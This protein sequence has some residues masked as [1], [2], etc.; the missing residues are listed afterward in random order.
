MNTFETIMSRK[1]VRKF[2]DEVISDSDLN[3]ILEAAMA[4]PSAANARPFEFL[5]IRDKKKLE[6][7]GEKA[8]KYSRPMKNATLGIVVCADKKRMFPDAPG[9]AAVDTTIAVENLILAAWDMGIGSVWLGVWPNES[10]MANVTAICGLPADTE[11]QH[12]IALGYPE[13]PM[14]NAREGRFE[15]NRIHYEKW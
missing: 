15:E 6:E 13:D 7:L 9:F 8:S 5:V 12:L 10:N 1:S 14:P 3:A 11:P 4:G 2:T